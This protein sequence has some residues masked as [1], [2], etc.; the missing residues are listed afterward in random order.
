MFLIREPCVYI[1][2]LRLTTATT[3][4]FITIIFRDK[5]LIIDH[6]ANWSANA[7]AGS[8][9]S[10]YWT[11]NGILSESSNR[12]NIIIRFYQSKPI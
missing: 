3:D 11:M 5:E 4:Q 10:K 12:T 6:V 1:S 9:P 8:I 7:Y 2:P